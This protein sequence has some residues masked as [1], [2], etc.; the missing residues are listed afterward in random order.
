MYQG[1]KIFKT[2]YKNFNNFLLIYYKY[3]KY[4]ILK[5]AKQHELLVFVFWSQLKT[6]V[7]FL[8]WD[9]FLSKASYVTIWSLH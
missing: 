9:E 5:Q 2:L 6:G 7:G 1:L 8:V 3:F 4:A